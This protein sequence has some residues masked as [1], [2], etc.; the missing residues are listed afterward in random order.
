MKFPGVYFPPIFF[1]ALAGMFYLYYRVHAFT[2]TRK[3][4]DLPARRSP[5][6]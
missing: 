6:N 4:S 2:T 3:V 1:F 5:S